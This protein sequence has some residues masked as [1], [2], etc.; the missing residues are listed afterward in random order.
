MTEIAARD[1]SAIETTVRLA[2]TGDE[3]A[4]ARLVSEH[5]PSMARVAYAITGDVDLAR[6]AVQSA[7]SIAWRKLGGL[8]DPGTVRSWLVAIAANEARQTLRRQRR[9]QLVD[10][11]DEL[12]GPTG[13]DP[14]STIGV[15]DLDRALRKLK[16]DERALLAL[17]YVGG[18][19]SNEIATQ[20][21]M[22]ASGVP[23]RLARLLDRLRQDLDHE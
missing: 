23:S 21:G 7:W 2:A 18:L 22:S 16:P 9:A 3:A 13:S 4:F 14:A 5:H 19:D 1:P 6:D 10:L 17:R 20:T 15:V 8:R 11:S 12:S